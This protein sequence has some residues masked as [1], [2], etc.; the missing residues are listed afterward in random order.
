MTQREYESWREF[1]R[2]FPFDDHHRLYRPAALVARSMGGGD[3]KSQLDWLSPDPAMAHLS[4]SD[5][6][7]LS[8]FGLKPPMRH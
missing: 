7:T 5:A 8:A 3:I 4:E 2:L 6:R 1:Y